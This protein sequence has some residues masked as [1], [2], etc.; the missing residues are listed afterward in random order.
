MRISDEQELARLI[1]PPR[2]CTYLPNEIASLEY[3]VLYGINETQYEG[4]LSRGWRRFGSHFFRPACQNCVKCR[5]IRI[6]VEAFRPDKNQRRCERRNEH[7]HVDLARA[8]LTRDHIELYN[9]YHRAMHDAKGWREKETDPQDYWTGFLSGD[10]PFA[11]EMRY[12]R[13]NE[14]VGIGLID[15]VP[16][17]TSSVYF[18]HH[19]DWRPDSPG[20]FSLLQELAL[21]KRLGKKYAYLGYWIP[22]NRSMAYKSAYHP[23]ELLTS[24]PDDDMEPPWQP[25]VP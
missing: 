6:D 3:R 2:E 7:I 9:A 15:I 25:P 1:E 12:F 21:A 19:P 23:H 8:S 5:S 11:H 24:F 18:F 22:E 13:G 20:T 17:S 16:T 10:W 14:L 4:L